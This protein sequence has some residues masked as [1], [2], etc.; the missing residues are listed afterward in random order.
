MKLK[1]KPLRRGAPTGRQLRR[2]A[3]KLGRTTKFGSAMKTLGFIH[4]LK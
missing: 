1:G 2:K 4:N 3:K